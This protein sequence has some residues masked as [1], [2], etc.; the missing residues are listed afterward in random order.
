MGF[1]GVAKEGLS[2]EAKEEIVAKVH[3]WGF[4][5]ITW[6][7]I[8]LLALFFSFS[9]FRSC[10]ALPPSL[11][12]P[13]LFPS[14]FAQCSSDNLNPSPLSPGPAQTT[15]ISKN[16]YH[17]IHPHITSLTSHHHFVTST[18]VNPNISHQ[19]VS[20]DNEMDRRGRPAYPRRDGQDLQSNQRAV[21]HCHEV[22]RA[23]WL[24]LHSFSFEV[25]TFFHHHIFPA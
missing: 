12:S 8:R 23:C 4:T 18:V 21:R 1:H 19:N 3:V 20:P 11:S 5:D 17:L 15:L 10:D 7:G 25:S 2:K 13:S 16:F 24:W 14:S 6:E 9:A 22:S